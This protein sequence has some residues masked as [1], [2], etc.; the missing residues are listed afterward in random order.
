[1]KVGV[2]GAGTMGAGI[3]QAFAQ[4]GKYDVF[5]CDVDRSLADNGKRKIE[6]ELLNKVKKGKLSCDDATKILARIETGT[7]SICRDCDL[8]VEAVVE[9]LP[10]KVK[11]FQELEEICKSDCIFT[12]NTSSLSI[13]EIG[14]EVTRPVVGMHFFNPAPVMSLVEIIAGLNTPDEILW[15]VHHV[16]DEIGK[17]PIR[18]EESPGFIVNRLIVPMMNEAIGLY[19]EGIASAEDIDH[20]M[21]LGAGNPMGPLELGDVIGWDIIL[22]VME[23]LQTDTGDQKYR[24]HPYLRKIVR[25]KRLG[26]KTGRG[27]YEYTRF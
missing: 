21:R 3:A 13:T 2:A 15:R 4:S 14:R 22:A 18:V 8:I 24:P 12:T 20:A 11:L 23:I 7:I 9:E 17:V 25:G 27:I 26:K 5:L 6:T 16:A 19:A 1:M 10:A